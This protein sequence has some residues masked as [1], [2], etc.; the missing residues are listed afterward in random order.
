MK[1]LETIANMVSESLEK[2]VMHQ[3]VQK[4]GEKN[5]I[6][7]YE[8]NISMIIYVDDLLSLSD[9]EIV[10]KILQ[11]YQNHKEQIS[12]PDNF[13]WLHDFQQVKD[14]LLVRLVSENDVRDRVCLPYLD[15]FKVYVINVNHN[16]FSDAAIRVNE[17]LLQIWDISLG[18]LDRIALENTEKTLPISCENMASVLKKM[19][20]AEDEDEIPEIPMSILSNDTKTYGATVILYPSTMKLLSEA[21]KA[22]KTDLFLIPS[23]VHEMLIIPRRTDDDVDTLKSMIREANDT[24]VKPDELL[25]YSLYR[26]D[27]DT[28]Q[29]V[30]A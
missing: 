13:D 2:K 16:D 24:Q 27:N 23:S 18:E 1:R 21:A 15:L 4:N 20:F 8:G 29:I 25:S 17:R 28:K 11:V 22:I 7:I 19:N 5:A 14:K 10:E 26:F 6:V 9:S 12:I 3:V 30:V